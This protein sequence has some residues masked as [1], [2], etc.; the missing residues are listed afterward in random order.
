MADGQ[1]REAWG[2]LSVLLAL[3]A[4][5]HRD[6]KKGRAYK[7]RDFD[8]TGGEPEQVTRVTRDNIGLLKQ[9]FVQNQGQKGL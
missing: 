9:A 1:A 2:R 4:N 6:P 8:P 7:P 3:T 5:C